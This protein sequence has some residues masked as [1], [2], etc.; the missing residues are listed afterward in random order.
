[1]FFALVSAI[2]CAVRPWKPPRKA[3]IAAR[4]VGTPA[5]LTAASTA[6][7]P[8]VGGKAAHRPPGQRAAQP[9]VE[10]QARFV[11]DDVL[12]P[13]QQLRGLRLD[14]GHDA[15][16]GVAGVRDTD[17]RAVVEIAAA[18]LRDEPGTLAALDVDVGHA[19]PDG[20]HDAVVGEGDWRG[21]E[22]HRITLLLRAGSASITPS[23]GAAPALPSPGA[24]RGR[25]RWR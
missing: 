23:P 2:V 9:L 22:S 16:V 10:A 7:A 5:R 6:S 18:I 4:P 14:G 21:G 13:V 19:A 17:A 8:A 1:M 3:M 12:L 25:R 20:G 24:G 11:E 15:R